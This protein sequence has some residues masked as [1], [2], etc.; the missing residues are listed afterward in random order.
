MIDYFPPLVNQDIS[1]QPS[2]TS[3][4]GEVKFL[5]GTGDARLQRQGRAQ[6]GGI[7]L[8]ALERA[9]HRLDLAPFGKYTYCRS[10][11]FTATNFPQLSTAPFEF[12]SDDKYYDTQLESSS[13]VIEID[14]NG[15]EVTTG[16]SNDEIGKL[17]GPESKGKTYQSL[18]GCI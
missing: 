12:G 18:N 10:P 13:L 4:P 17:N 3:S 16:C 14:S 9:G 7:H 2:V 1:S 8:C 6:C 5:V 11:A 15:L